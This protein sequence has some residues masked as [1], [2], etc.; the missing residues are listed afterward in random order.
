M[1]RH[2]N[3]SRQVVA[4][5]YEPKRESA[6]RVVAKGRGYLAEKIPE[7]ARGEAGVVGRGL[8]REP[9]VRLDVRD[10]GKRFAELVRVEVAVRTLPHAPRDV[11]VERERRQ[12][13]KA[14]LA[15]RGGGLDGSDR[16]QRPDDSAAGAAP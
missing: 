7:L 11:D 10:V 15:A 8:K 4:L 5:R 2:P 6:P 12:R 9:V 3:H 13:G 1:D 14:E 16:H